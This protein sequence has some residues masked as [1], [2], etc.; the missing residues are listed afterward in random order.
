MFHHVINYQQVSI[1]F[2]IIGVDLQ[3]YKEYNKICDMEY[4]EPPKVTT[5]VPNIST[6]SYYS[7]NATLTVM[8]KVIDTC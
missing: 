2:G 7:F 6:F 1:P 5:N 4:R 3:E 8:I